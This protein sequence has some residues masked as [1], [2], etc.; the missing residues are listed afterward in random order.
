MESFVIGLLLFITGH[1]SITQGALLHL[2]TLGASL[3][4]LSSQMY[5]VLKSYSVLAPLRGG[6]VYTRVKNNNTDNKIEKR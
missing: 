1:Q 5:R 4:I 6:A 3:I 2:T